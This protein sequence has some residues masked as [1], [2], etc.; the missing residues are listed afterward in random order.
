MGPRGV[1]HGPPGDRM[2][3]CTVDCLWTPPKNTRPLRLWRR[4]RLDAARCSSR[5]P[6]DIPG[7]CLLR[8]PSPPQQKTPGAPTGARAWQKCGA[9]KRWNAPDAEGRCAS[10]SHSEERRSSQLRIIGILPRSGKIRTGSM[11]LFGDSSLPRTSTRGM[12][13]SR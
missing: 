12:P 4:A 1:P 6:L 7:R 10:K 11:D 2:R 13:L 3:S 5:P 9:K 8:A